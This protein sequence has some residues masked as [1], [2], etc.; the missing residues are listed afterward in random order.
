MDA[1]HLEY[2]DNC[3]DLIIDKGTF[4]CVISGEDSFERAN[5]MISVINIV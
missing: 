3:F 1:C 5:S 2:P 4:D